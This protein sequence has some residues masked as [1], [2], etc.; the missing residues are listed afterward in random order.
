MSQ[1]IVGNQCPRCDGNL[2]NQ[3]AF[4]VEISRMIHYLFCLDCG[5]EIYTQDKKQMVLA[6]LTRGGMRTKKDYNYISEFLDVPIEYVKSLDF[7]D[8]QGTVPV[9]DSLGRYAVKKEENDENN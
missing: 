6:M 1:K 5:N 9:N 2:R 3:S 7:H 8:K 4:D